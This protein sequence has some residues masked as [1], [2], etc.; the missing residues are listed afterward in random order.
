MAC[1]CPYYVHWNAYCKHMA[2]V[3]TAIDDGTLNVFPSRRVKTMPTPKTVTATVSVVSRVSHACKR[4]GQ[5]CQTNHRFSS[6]IHDT[7][8]DVLRHH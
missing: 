1:T 2:A 4:D 5:N 3:E 7:P 8:I 6:F